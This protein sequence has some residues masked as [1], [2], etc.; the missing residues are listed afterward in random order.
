MLPHPKTG[1]CLPAGPP[2]FS[3]LCREPGAF[4][5]LLSPPCLTP[6]LP[7]I[8]SP[9]TQHTHPM[10]TGP[11]LTHML[12]HSHTHSH[13]TQ[14]SQDLIHTT[15]T[16]S[17][18][19]TKSLSHISHTHNSPTHDLTHTKFADSQLSH[20]HT[21]N[22]HTAYTHGHTHNSNTVSHTQL[23]HHFTHSQRVSLTHP[24]TS[25]THTTLLH[26]SSHTQNSP[27]V[28]LS[29]L[30]HMQLSHSHTHNSHMQYTHGHTHIHTPLSD[31]TSHLYSQFSHGHSHGHTLISH[32]H[33][34][35][36]TPC[37]SVRWVDSAHLFKLLPGLAFSPCDEIPMLPLVPTPSSVTLS[38]P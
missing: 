11:R 7:V 5:S 13:F 2:V 4:C 21:C 29:H 1:R 25:L 18:T 30:T 31:T 6:M 36:H 34:H 3:F 35:S 22:S 17:Y 32:T 37:L 38:R 9:S 14:L 28:T 15:L 24:H 16:P 20:S 12:T 8:A 19:L 27:M 26:I 33:T 23:S 10:F